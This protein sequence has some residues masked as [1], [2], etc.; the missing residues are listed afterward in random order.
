MVFVVKLWLYKLINKQ[1][2]KH[3]LLHFYYNKSIINFHMGLK[4]TQR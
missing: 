4:I 3:G 2:K 1:K